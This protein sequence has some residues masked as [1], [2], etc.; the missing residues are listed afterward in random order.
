MSTILSYEEVKTEFTKRGYILLSTHYK[1][2]ALLQYT[3]MKHPTEISSIRLDLL[4]SGRGCPYCAGKFTYA[5]VKAEFANRGYEL[6]SEVYKTT[7][8]KLKYKCLKH[9]NKD[10]SISLDCLLRGQG[11]KYCAGVAKPLYEEVKAEF[12]ARGYELIS[13]TY[14]N[15]NSLLEYKCLKHSNY[16]LKIRLGAFRKGQGCKYCSFEYRNNILRLDYS[17]VKHEFEKRGYILLSDQYENAGKLLKYRCNNHPEYILSIRYCSLKSGSG[18]KY[19]SYKKNSGAN[20]CKWKG[21]ITKLNNYLRESDIIKNW[22][23]KNLNAQ[24]YKCQVTGKNSN[25][26]HVHHASIG[27]SD[28]VN[29]ILNNLGLIK[30]K[31]I[32]DYSI[33]DLN[34]ILVMLENYHNN[35]E[36]IVLNKKVHDLF[37]KVYGRSKNNLE[38]FIEFKQRYKNGEF[39]NV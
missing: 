11:C 13:D 37:H 27:F 25:K 6:I 35:C 17:E 28:I 1:S 5:Q 32:I 26:L 33:N 38:Q 7:H 36:G 30:N 9:I 3:C 8:S 18:C 29:L 23:I 24:S 22:K 21:G 31:A 15:A 12:S 39:N 14:E 34:N 19:C 16:I 4:K 10:L 20:H 2:K